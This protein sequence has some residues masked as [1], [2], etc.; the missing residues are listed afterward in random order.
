MSRYGSELTVRRI[1]T[2]AK[3]AR[4]FERSCRLRIWRVRYYTEEG[5]MDQLQYASDQVHSSFSFEPLPDTG[6]RD[7]GNQ[8]HPPTRSRTRVFWRLSPFFPAWHRILIPDRTR[9]LR[10]LCP[11][12]SLRLTQE[13]T[14]T[15]QPPRHEPLRFVRRYA[16]LI[17]FHTIVTCSLFST[18]RDCAI[19][20]FFVR[21][22]YYL[23]IYFIN[24]FRNCAMEFFNSVHST[25]YFSAPLVDIFQ[26]YA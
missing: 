16:S 22:F 23:S 9:V 17:H 5:R 6:A 15:I 4:V 10:P 1:T 8:F 12:R 18:F 19:A 3:N 24:L 13:K 7:V 25:C 20:D 14:R 21:L 2:L 26:H 11:H